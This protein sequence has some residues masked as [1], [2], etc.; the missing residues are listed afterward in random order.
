MEIGAP[1]ETDPRPTEMMP[2]TLMSE[3]AL[4][5]AWLV[6]M[7]VFMSDDEDIMS[8]ELLP[9]MLVEAEDCELVSTFP[10]P[11]V[12]PIAATPVMPV[13]AEL[14]KG[15][16]IAANAAAP[17]IEPIIFCFIVVIRD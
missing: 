14:E 3:P 5:S 8:E 4:V 1:T 17:A 10:D 12:A 11:T 7:L 2:P 15:R 16:I 6:F 9:I 13:W